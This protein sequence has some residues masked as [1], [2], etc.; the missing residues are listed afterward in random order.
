MNTK[1][2]RSIGVIIF[3]MKSG[4]PEF[5][6][7]KHRQGHWSFPKGHMEKGETDLQTAKRELSEETG[8]TD[9]KFISEGIELSEVY[10]FNSGKNHRVEK[11]VDYFIAEVFSETV[12]IDN[13]EIV[14]FQW[15]G[16]DKGLKLVTFPE[17]ENLLNKAYKIIL[18]KNDKEIS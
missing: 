8:I 5:L 11:S 1:K 17:S 13:M 18:N 15:C 14:N 6:I 7:I 3:F 12:K 4:V 16:L 9:V 10:L 2:D